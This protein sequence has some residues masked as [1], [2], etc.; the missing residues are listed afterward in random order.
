VST[1]SLERTEGVLTGEGW[2][3]IWSWWDEG[4]LLGAKYMLIIT[5]DQQRYQPLYMLDGNLSERTL[6]IYK[7]CILEIYDLNE[8]RVAQMYER[9]AWNGPKRKNN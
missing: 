9:R 5:F 1:T 8:G 2:R 4:V 3:D 6:Q 7:G